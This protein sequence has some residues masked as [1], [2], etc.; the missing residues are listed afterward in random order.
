MNYTDM[1]LTEQFPSSR[2]GI[3][4]CNPISAL[5]AGRLEGTDTLAT[6]FCARCAYQKQV[7][8]LSTRMRSKVVGSSGIFATGRNARSEPVLIATS[9]T[10]TTV[11][12]PGSQ[13]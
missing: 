2:V 6:R 11:K 1:F 10:G 12:T 3:L 9:V 4:D 8:G 7:A 13:M 5:S